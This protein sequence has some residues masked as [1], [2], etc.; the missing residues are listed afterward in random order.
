MQT[1]ND[2][3]NSDTTVCNTSKTLTHTSVS[4]PKNL[5]PL[6]AWLAHQEGKDKMKK[7]GLTK[8]I[9][10]QDYMWNREKTWKEL[11]NAVL[12]KEVCIYTVQLN[13]L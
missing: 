9:L 2:D 10:E 8:E 13:I 6:G 12:T 7:L 1:S 5:V 3:M 11:E 4:C